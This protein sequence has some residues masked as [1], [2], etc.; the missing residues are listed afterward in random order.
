VGLD[1]QNGTGAGGKHLSQQHKEENVLPF[2]ILPEFSDEVKKEMWSTASLLQ[3]IYLCG[4]SI[5]SVLG[6]LAIVWLLWKFAGSLDFWLMPQVVLYAILV[7]WCVRSFH[8][9]SQV[10]IEKEGPESE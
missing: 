2:F 9:E 1:K 7:Y 8:E 10:R 3:L 6:S 4:L 5:F